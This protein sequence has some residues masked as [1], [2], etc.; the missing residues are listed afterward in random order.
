MSVAKYFVVHLSER[1][2]PAAREVFE[3]QLL[4]LEGRATAC[5]YIGSGDTDLAIEG[6]LIP[7]AVLQ[8]ARRQ[9]LGQGDYVDD[10]GNSIPP[11]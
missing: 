5:G 10:D 4:D 7:A 11:F 8:A 3:I 2:R 1:D 6:R 9:P